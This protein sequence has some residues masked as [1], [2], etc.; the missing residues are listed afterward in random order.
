MATD[1][2]RLENHEHVSPTKFPKL[3]NYISR[4]MGHKQEPPVPL[5]QDDLL[6]F[7]FAKTPNTDNDKEIH[8]L[9][10]VESMLHGLR[11]IPEDPTIFLNNLES[12]GLVASFDGVKIALIDQKVDPPTA[13]AIILGNMEIYLATADDLNL[14][15]VLGKYSGDE[16]VAFIA[17]KNPTQYQNQRELQTKFDHLLHE[18]KSNYYKEPFFSKATAALKE[19]YP[20]EQL[21]FTSRYTT[22]DQVHVYSPQI[23]KK[24]EGQL[25][26]DHKATPHAK[27]AIGACI[28]AADNKGVRPSESSIPLIDYLK[29][30]LTQNLDAVVQNKELEGIF[31]KDLNV[32]KIALLQADLNAHF[33]ISNSDDIH[34]IRFADVL[35]KH[36]NKTDGHTK[37]DHHMVATVRM[38]RRLLDELKIKQDTVNIYQHN[39]SF[40]MTAPKTVY[41]QVAPILNDPITFN[42]NFA[43]LED[44]REPLDG[45]DIK[46]RAAP[47]VVSTTTLIKNGARAPLALNR[48]NYTEKLWESISDLRIMQITNETIAT[49][50]TSGLVS[51]S[52]VHIISTIDKIITFAGLK[53]IPFDLTQLQEIQSLDFIA[54]FKYYSSARPTSVNYAMMNLLKQGVIDKEEY[55]QLATTE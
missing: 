9:P 7:F 19:Y 31:P 49:Y 26:P 25:I 39:G 17:P 13:D 4:V 23:Y 34:L 6:Q 48:E 33:A 10:R 55:Y 45:Q 2:N 21:G 16:D 5:S 46:L 43:K 52:F 29:D 12:C 24:S 22:L 1:Q 11:N 28:D 47:F 40:V 37:G 51:N 30:S 50:I 53:H 32:R 14:E 20:N 18:K 42:T 36:V 38:V 15:I 27:Q 41:D 44:R 8:H 35:M 3:E 54:L